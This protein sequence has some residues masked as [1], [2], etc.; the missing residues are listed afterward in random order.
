MKVV[1]GKALKRL[2]P[3]LFIDAVRKY[4]GEILRTLSWRFKL[5]KLNFRTVFYSF[6]CAQKVVNTCYFYTL[7]HLNKRLGMRQ[8]SNP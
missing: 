3:L 5:Q 1:V 8:G 7:L 6:T 2:V 4:S